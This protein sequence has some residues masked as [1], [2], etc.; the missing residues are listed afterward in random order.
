MFSRD[1]YIV[2]LP[3]LSKPLSGYEMLVGANG[4]SRCDATCEFWV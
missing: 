4:V 1:T 2:P 3:Q